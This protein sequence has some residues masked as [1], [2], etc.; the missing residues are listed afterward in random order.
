MV[1]GGAWWFVV[2]SRFAGYEDKGTNL[3]S[4]EPS[5]C[6]NEHQLPCTALIHQDRR[7]V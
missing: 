1:Q 4:K 2:T 5:I 3:Q 7:E 6:Q